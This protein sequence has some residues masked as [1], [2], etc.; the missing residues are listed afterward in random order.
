MV[1]ILSGKQLLEMAARNTSG[2]GTA[3]SIAELVNSV[4]ELQCILNVSSTSGSGQSLLLKV[5]ESPDGT[6]GWSDA[7]E[8]SASSSA[9]WQMSPFSCSQPYL[10]ASYNISGSSASF[11]FGVDVV[12]MSKWK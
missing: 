9:G 10:R 6:S 11:T 2:T 12:G 5:Q 3:V 8:F 4:E 1:G 7:K